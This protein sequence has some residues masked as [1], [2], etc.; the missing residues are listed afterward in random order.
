MC[1][2]RGIPLTKDGLLY[3]A[4]KL[5]QEGHGTLVHSFDPNKGPGRRWYNSFM[6]RHSTL[7]LRT[8]EYLHKGRALIS[9][10]II[11]KWFRNVSIY[12]FIMM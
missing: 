7:A 11:R 2:K 9:E 12:L 5:L 8:P 6:E 10:E 1:A 3:S 4:N